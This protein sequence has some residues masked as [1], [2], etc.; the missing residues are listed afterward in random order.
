MTE[1]EVLEEIATKLGITVEELDKPFDCPDYSMA[2]EWLKIYFESLGKKPRWVSPVV[3]SDD[4][5]IDDCDS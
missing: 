3:I 4:K 2:K 5:I 1:R